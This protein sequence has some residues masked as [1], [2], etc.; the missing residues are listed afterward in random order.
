ML[1]DMPTSSVKP[2]QSHRI[3]GNLSAGDA[4]FTTRPFAGIA[5]LL[6]VAALFLSLN[7]TPVVD[8]PINIALIVV[9]AIVAVAALFAAAL[10]TRGAND[11]Q[12]FVLIYNAYAYHVFRG[13]F[14]V[15]V[16]AWL[17]NVGWI[18]VWMVLFFV[19]MNSSAATSTAGTRPLNRSGFCSRRCAVRPTVW[20]PH[21]TSA[22][23]VRALADP[24]SPG[25]FRAGARSIG[26]TTWPESSASGRDTEPPMVYSSIATITSRRPCCRNCARSKVSSAP[27]CSCAQ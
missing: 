11:A 22:P 19:C 9:T 21:L 25:P 24:G 12:P 14:V 18:A 13:K 6:V 2:R 8:G 27:T 1:G 26:W 10:A 7:I 23:L 20:T 17:R 3:G 15:P 4:R 16:P 5:S